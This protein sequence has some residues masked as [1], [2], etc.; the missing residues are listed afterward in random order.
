MKNTILAYT[1]VAALSV[2]LC[3][4]EEEEKLPHFDKLL[5][6]TDV[7]VTK[8]NPDSISIRHDSGTRTVPF[9]ELPDDARKKLGMTVEAVEGHRTAI[10]D[11]ANRK[12]EAA[13]VQMREE[14]LSELLFS[15]VSGKVL[16][17]LDD[18]VLLTDAKKWMGM[19]EKKSYF[20]SGE[21][22]NITLH[23]AYELPIGVCV[24][25]CDTTG[26]VDGHL[27][28]RVVGS[29]G[30]FTYTTALNTRKT[31]NAY[32]TDLKAA[33]KTLAEASG[34]SVENIVKLSETRLQPEK[35][36]FKTKQPVER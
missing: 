7:T 22:A 8:I 30:T 21:Y 31:C 33:C 16:Q 14:G 5:N 12:K 32:T 4:G 26:I 19:M 15:R 27:F 17:V 1:A 13:D 25:S 28:T 24:V 23:S 6:Y 20:D 2:L 11:E 3:R 9:D 34:L 35:M 29:A 18:G 36:F 10:A